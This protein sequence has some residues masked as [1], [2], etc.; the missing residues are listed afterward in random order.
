MRFIDFF[1][2]LLEKKSWGE[3]L[4][5]GGKIAET[6]LD[7]FKNGEMSLTPPHNVYNTT[8]N[9]RDLKI[10]LKA[11]NNYKNDLNDANGVMTVDSEGNPVVQLFVM[12]LL[13]NG[14][15]KTNRNYRGIPSDKL[16]KIFLN[17]LNKG[18]SA[19][20]VSNLQ[21]ELIHAMEHNQNLRAVT[22]VSTSKIH[23]NTKNAKYIMYLNKPEEVHARIAQYAAPINRK[24][25]EEFNRS[26][27]STF[28]DD[29]MHG[30]VLEIPHAVKAFKH[31]HLLD[32][33][34][35]LKF[36]RGIRHVLSFA[37]EY[38]KTAHDARMKVKPISGD[39]LDTIINKI[40]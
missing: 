26:E 4:I 19:S 38:Y 6:I 20:I 3:S 11:F 7:K 9:G 24:W 39:E 18:Q 16:N 34:N 22:S 17:F 12:E 5:E 21:H 28:F 31:L 40:V 30:P 8:F 37:W 27:D 10:I 14:V 32:K 1:N 33:E 25:M 29:V 36:K 15:F 35:Q 13:G 2:P 23:G